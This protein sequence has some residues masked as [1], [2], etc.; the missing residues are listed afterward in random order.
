MPKL[1]VLGV[2]KGQRLMFSRIFEVELSFEAVQTEPTV[3]RRCRPCVALVA[4]M[5]ASLP[6]CRAQVMGNGTLLS[7][8]SISFP[9]PP[10]GACTMPVDR[11][12]V[13]SASSS[14]FS[15]LD[16]HPTPLLLLPP[17][18][19]PAAASHTGPQPATM[20]LTR[21]ASPFLAPSPVGRS[22]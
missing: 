12:D 18:A 3:H 8:H 1:K 20:A 21:R 11:P 17:V 7:T 9:H 19:L 4:C 13:S 2:T 14:L 10:P 16:S 6:L 22:S 15:K 5:A